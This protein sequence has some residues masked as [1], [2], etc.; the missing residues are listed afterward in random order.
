MKGEE[1]VVY[2]E[3]EGVGWLVYGWVWVWFG[4]SFLL[5]GIE[6]FNYGDRLDGGGKDFWVLFV[7]F[8][9]F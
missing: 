1:F 6:V 7:F 4:F 3:K 2:E 9:G 5:N 8:W